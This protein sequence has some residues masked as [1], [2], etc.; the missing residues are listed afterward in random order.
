V[1]RLSRPA[2]RAR[3]AQVVLAGALV[4]TPVAAAAV[5]APAAAAT[6][7]ISMTGVPSAAPALLLTR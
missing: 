2:R 1:T 5:P 3:V 7:C 6:P 4:L